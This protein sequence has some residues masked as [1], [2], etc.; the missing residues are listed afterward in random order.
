VG[1]D[2]DARWEAVKARAGKG[3][4]PAWALAGAIHLVEDGNQLVGGVESGLCRNLDLLAK[5][6]LLVTRVAAR[7]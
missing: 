7:L 6:G 4:A 1:P 5:G 2:S 3:S